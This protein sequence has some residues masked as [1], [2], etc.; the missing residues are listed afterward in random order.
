[1]AVSRV[2]PVDI[3]PVC[4]S[5]EQGAW[6]SG[7]RVQCEAI[8]EHACNN[9]ADKSVSGSSFLLLLQLTKPKVATHVSN[10]SGQMVCKSR[11]RVIVLSIFCD[12]CDKLSLERTRNCL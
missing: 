4:Q 10:V 1:M 3:K 12:G 7:Q 6:K 9:L 11:R 5:G 2:C 8:A